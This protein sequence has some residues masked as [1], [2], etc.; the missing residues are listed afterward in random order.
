MLTGSHKL[1]L[2]DT[3]VGVGV[4]VPGIDHY[5]EA[6]GRWIPNWRRQWKK[7]MLKNQK[8]SKRR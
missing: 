1:N 7:R 5:C 2:N 8:W 4:L 6:P 3:E